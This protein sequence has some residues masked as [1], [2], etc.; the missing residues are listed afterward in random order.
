MVDDTTNQP[1][2]ARAS[3]KSGTSGA[4]CA[5]ST[6]NTALPDASM[7]RAV[8][9]WVYNATAMRRVG[10]MAGPP[11]HYSS[12]AAFSALNLRHGGQL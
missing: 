3:P 8:A 10:L 2:E 5:L 11:L 12:S 6:C 1:P 4:C 7:L 9:V